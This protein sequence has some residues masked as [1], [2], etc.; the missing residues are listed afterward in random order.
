[1]S[2][3]ARRTEWTMLDT[4]RRVRMSQPNVAFD[5]DCKGPAGELGVWY[6]VTVDFICDATAIGAGTYGSY[7]FTG[8]T[9]SELRPDNPNV[10]P[11]DGITFEIKTAIA[12]FEGNPVPP[13]SASTYRAN[14]SF[15]TPLLAV[16]PF[17]EKVL[18]WT[19]SIEALTDGDDGTAW[20]PV[21]TE[22]LHTYY[23]QFLLSRKQNVTGF[24]LLLDSSITATPNTFTIS[25]GAVNDSTAVIERFY[26]VPACVPYNGLVTFML[27]ATLLTDELTLSFFV[28]DSTSLAVYTVEFITSDSATGSPRVSS[29][30][31]VDSGAG[32][33]SALPPA[34]LPLLPANV[35]AGSVLKTF[36]LFD[37]YATDIALDADERVYV[38]N[39]AG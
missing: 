28:G 31:S 27:N 3:P 29:F 15:V 1:M 9:F 37:G 25:Q 16:D 21:S 19:T 24:T 18:D 20:Q 30:D 6:S 4:G 14:Y 38:Q 8:M 11:C 35:Q 17:D 33:C 39:G 23:A 32:N 36:P 12:C 13:C 2:F 34:Y 22:P 10:T 26:M 5:R 7:N